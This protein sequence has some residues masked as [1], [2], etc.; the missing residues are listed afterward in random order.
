MCNGGMGGHVC[1]VATESDSIGTMAASGRSG[2]VLYLALCYTRPPLKTCPLES[3]NA[4]LKGV[5]AAVC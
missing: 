4:A 2:R 3:S 1:K 5:K